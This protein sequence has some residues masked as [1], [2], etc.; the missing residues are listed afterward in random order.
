MTQ[1]LTEFLGLMAVFSVI[2]VAPGVCPHPR[3]ARRVAQV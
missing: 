3:S 2:I 1:Y